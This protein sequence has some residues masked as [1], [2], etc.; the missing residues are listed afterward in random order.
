MLTLDEAIEHCNEV[1]KQS[2]DECAKEHRQL[3]EWLMELK[4]C[5]WI[6]CESELPKCNDEFL[7]TWTTSECKRHFLA[8][9]EYDVDEGW[10]IA[11]YMKLY[12]NVNVIA[13]ML[14][15]EPYKEDE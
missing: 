13:W 12:R 5:R 4:E 1:G 2:C 11:E 10:I 15:P 7:V 6:S 14:L 3:A 8:M 9:L